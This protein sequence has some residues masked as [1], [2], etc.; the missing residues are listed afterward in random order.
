MAQFLPIQ[1]QVISPDLSLPFPP[2]AKRSIRVIGVLFFIITVR[3][4][5]AKIV[6]SLLPQPS[7]L[8]ASNFLTDGKLSRYTEEG[9][10]RDGISLPDGAHR[11][12]LYIYFHTKP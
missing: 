5:Y 10:R 8:V 11:P 9:L 7:V 12:V 4:E 1:V 3:V 2:A 6:T